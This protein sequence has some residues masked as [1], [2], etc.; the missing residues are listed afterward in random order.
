M[1]LSR[2][3]RDSGRHW[4]LGVECRYGSVGV[5]LNFAADDLSS[6]LANNLTHHA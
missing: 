1:M 4:S 5:G 3:E 2:P 6:E